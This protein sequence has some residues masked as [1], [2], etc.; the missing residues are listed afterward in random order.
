[1]SPDGKN[2]GGSGRNSLIGS[3]EL[4]RDSSIDSLFNYSDPTHIVFIETA[5]RDTTYRPGKTLRLTLNPGN[6]CTY[7]DLRYDPETHYLPTRTDTSRYFLLP[8]KIVLPDDLRPANDTFVYSLIDTTLT[9]RQTR[10]DGPG[11]M[12]PT[13]YQRSDR[14]L[15]FLK[16]Q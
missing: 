11:T 10:W 5:V 1:M 14:T 2:D 6:F 9:L 3:W 8:G 13:N 4:I 7:A 15:V 16:H 12:W